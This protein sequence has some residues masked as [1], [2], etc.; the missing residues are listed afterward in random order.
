[1]FD[2]QME[3]LSTV[4]VGAVS[5]IDAGGDADAAWQRSADALRASDVEEAD[6]SAAIEG[7]DLDAL[8]AILAAWATDQRLLPVHDREVLKRAMKAYR[9]T[10]KVTRLDAESSIGGGPMSSGRESSIAGVRPPDRYPRP[11]WDELVRQGKLID[12]R[13]GMYELGPKA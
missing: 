4:L 13:F 6:I 7:K 12:V 11:V 8:R 5:D 9:K 10:L 3:L 1:M 2:P